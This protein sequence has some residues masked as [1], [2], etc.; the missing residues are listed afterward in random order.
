MIKRK[1]L[2]RE[3]KNQINCL[4]AICQQ[5]EGLRTFEGH[6]KEPLWVD[7]FN[8]DFLTKDERKN[9]K[10]AHTFL[11]KF[12]DSVIQ[13]LDDVEQERIKKQMLKFDF[14]LLDDYTLQKVFRKM[15]DSMKEI[16]MDRTV[17]YKYCEDI[18]HVNCNGCEKDGGTCDL[19]KSF[20]DNMVPDFGAE[21]SNC[22]YA[23]K[24]ELKKK[25][26]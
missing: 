12:L 11:L 10:S 6:S 18:M 21:C 9:I 19:R 14:K 3:E 8:R 25:E 22:K 16:V 15:N 1:Y 4:L 13:R 5:L 26:A 24:L 7:W 17:F 2:N 23:Y 20:E